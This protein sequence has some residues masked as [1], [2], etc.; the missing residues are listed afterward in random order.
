MKKINS[1]PSVKKPNLSTVEEA[2]DRKGVYIFQDTVVKL[3]LRGFFTV[4]KEGT[5][6]MHSTLRDAWRAM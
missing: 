3:S 4:Q 5:T 2:L 1:Y 6:R